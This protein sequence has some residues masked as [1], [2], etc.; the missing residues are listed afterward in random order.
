M[1][2]DKDIRMLVAG[3]LA[4]ETGALFQSEES[5]AFF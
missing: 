2:T 5:N 3:M 1:L 4:R